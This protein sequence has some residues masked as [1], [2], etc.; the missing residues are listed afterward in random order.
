MVTSMGAVQNHEDEEVDDTDRNKG[1][2]G[3]SKWKK[4]VETSK[5]DGTIDV[6]IKHVEWPIENIFHLE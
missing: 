1:E 4:K 3:H 2:Q 6:D 5:Y